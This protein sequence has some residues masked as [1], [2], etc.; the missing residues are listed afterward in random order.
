MFRSTAENKATGTVFP[1]KFL[2][3]LSWRRWFTCL[4]TFITQRITLANYHQSLGPCFQRLK[5]RLKCSA[6]SLT[7]IKCNHQQLRQSLWVISYSTLHHKLCF[8]NNSLLLFVTAI[9]LNRHQLCSISH[10]L[11]HSISNSLAGHFS[12]SR[13][14]YINTFLGIR[15]RFQNSMRFLQA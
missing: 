6:H 15:L 14:K 4:K 11:G 12:Q 1:S 10:E 7:N 3:Y 5:A 8:G 2:S 9:N 13:K